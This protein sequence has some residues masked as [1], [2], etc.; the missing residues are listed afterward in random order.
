VG[1]ASASGSTNSTFELNGSGIA[2]SFLNTNTVTG[3][4]DTNFNSTVPGRY[5]FQFHNGEPL[6]TP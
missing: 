2:R 3:L 6:G 1:Y 5:V 4:I